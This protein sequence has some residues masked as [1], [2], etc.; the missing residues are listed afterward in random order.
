MKFS[1]VAFFGSAVLAGNIVSVIYTHVIDPSIEV[2]LE[3][4]SRSD[5]HSNYATDESAA[6]LQQDFQAA[7]DRI[8]H[9][10]SA[11]VV[12]VTPREYNS[13]EYLK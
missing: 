8:N 11:F 1:N 2:D 7:L 4:A 12:K 13:L 10:T 9:G 3:N 5:L 6:R